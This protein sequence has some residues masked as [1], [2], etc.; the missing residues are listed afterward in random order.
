MIIIGLYI[1]V[2]LLFT[3]M[4]VTS[5]GLLAHSGTV[6]TKSLYP[7]LFPIM[8]L[9]FSISA[10]LSGRSLNELDVLFSGAQDEQLT[11]ATMWINRLV[12]LSTLVIC[13]ERIARFVFV[14][15]SRATS[16]WYI[17]WAFFIFI[18]GNVFLNGIFGTR[19][20]FN[21]RYI[22]PVIAMLAAFIVAQGEVIRV[23]RIVRTSLFVFL[24]A[25][26][27]FLVVKPS[28]VLQGNYL[29]ILPGLHYRYWGLSPHANSMGP[30]MVVFLTCLWTEPYL[31]KWLNRVCWFLGILS[32]LM[33]QS[34]TSFALAMMCAAILATT[35]FMSKPRKQLWQRYSTLFITVIGSALL[36]FSI[37][38]IVIMFTDVMR[39]IEKFLATKAGGELLSLTGRD[40][41]W[42]VA[43][44]E[45]HRNIWF[46]YGPSMWDL[47]Y[48]MQ[49]GMLYA[50]H[51]HNQFFQSLGS[52]GL[53]GVSTLT[54]YAGALVVS[55]IKSA[56]ASKGLSLALL[57]LLLIQSIT[58]APLVLN[59]IARPD[60]FIHLLTFVV[61]VGYAGYSKLMVDEVAVT[62]HAPKSFR[63]QNE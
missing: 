62:I 5:L 7:L 23:V 20:E 26:A 45:W 27:A 38:C 37:L 52:G 42:A 40:R 56:R 43:I 2:T 8:V 44:N 9:G 54:V 1:F 28:L 4:V 21:H 3:G 48:R 12:S 11:G 53:V 32:L 17:F 35:W 46:G 58:E 19:P 22:Y 33:S 6:R 31:N 29:G 25:S 15:S 59:G 30:L 50:F 41:I 60:F 61:C 24:L 49:T 18:L 51:A 55:A 13:L 47:P 34:K 63:W 39:P 36:I 16:N 14:K 57:M 10:L